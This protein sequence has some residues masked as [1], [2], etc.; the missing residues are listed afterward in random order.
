ME[1]VGAG[2][3]APDLGAST[4]WHGRRRMALSHL[5]LCPNARASQARLPKLL[6][7]SAGQIP[8]DLGVSHAL[9]V[10]ATSV[11]VTPFTFEGSRRAAESAKP[12]L[13]QHSPLWKSLTLN[14]S[15][16]FQH[17]F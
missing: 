1:D 8:N 7:A 16:P 10:P 4:A 6:D 11:F 2:A 15:A 3:R 14:I 9:G 17:R 5:A 13:V 12:N